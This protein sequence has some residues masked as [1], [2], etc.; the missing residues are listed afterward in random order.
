MIVDFDSAI[1]KFMSLL[2]QDLNEWDFD[3]EN[4]RGEIVT[5]VEVPFMHKPMAIGIN[6]NRFV[7][8]LEKCGVKVSKSDIDT[9]IGK[10]AEHLTII[11]MVEG[12]TDVMYDYSSIFIYVSEK[13]FETKEAVIV[14]EKPVVKIDWKEKGLALKEKGLALW[15]NVKKYVKLFIEA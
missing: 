2:E 14:E 10:L 6:F 7:L 15:N 8:I 1:E 13:Y 5:A 11:G 3:D 4:H 9:F 12:C